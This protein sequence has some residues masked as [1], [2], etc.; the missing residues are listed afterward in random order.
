MHLRVTAGHWGTKHR[1]GHGWKEVS[2]PRRETRVL[3]PE[4]F[5]SRLSGDCWRESRHW[6]GKDRDL[7]SGTMGQAFHLEMIM[8]HVCCDGG[9]GGRW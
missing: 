3:V 8:R 9:D 4:G 7:S 6:N 5:I 2:L 1:V